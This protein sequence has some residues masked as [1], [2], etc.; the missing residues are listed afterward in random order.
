VAGGAKLL[1]DIV[2]R[3]EEQWSKRR[4]SKRAIARERARMALAKGIREAEVRYE[5]FLEEEAVEVLLLS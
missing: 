3:D 1:H 2:S 4:K 5:E